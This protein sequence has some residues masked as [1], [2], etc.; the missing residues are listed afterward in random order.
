MGVP[1]RVSGAARCQVSTALFLVSA[2]LA[3][4]RY[5]S[6][7][8]RAQRALGL[9]EG[10]EGVRVSRAF[11]WGSRGG[12]GGGVGGGRGGR[13]ARRGG[14]GGGGGGGGDGG[15]GFWGVPGVPLA[16]A[17]PRPE[18]TAQYARPVPCTFHGH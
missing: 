6:R 13:G 17:V 4:A 14:G 1:F 2:G 8:W 7:L 5:A 12:G 18:G 9:G 11:F 10:R 15:T 3:S 16:L